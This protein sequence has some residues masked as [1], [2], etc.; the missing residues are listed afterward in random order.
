MALSSFYPSTFSNRKVHKVHPRKSYSPNEYVQRLQ[1]NLETAQEEDIDW[2]DY[3]E[4]AVLKD[5][6]SDKD[7]I[8]QSVEVLKTAA[9]TRKVPASEIVTAF[10]VLAKANLDPTNFLSIVGGT[11][12][13]GRKWLLIFT[14]NKEEYNSIEGKGAYLPITAVQNFDAEVSQSHLPSPS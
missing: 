14:C 8:K 3:A 9:K 11:K 4:S 5:S 13:P 2:I 7:T 12:S 10:K 1:L 6:A